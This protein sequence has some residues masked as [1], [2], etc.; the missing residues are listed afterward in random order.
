MIRFYCCFYRAVKNNFGKS[1]IERPPLCNRSKYRDGSEGD[2]VLM[3][4]SAQT[5]APKL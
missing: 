2:L 1:E 5:H 3:V 4:G